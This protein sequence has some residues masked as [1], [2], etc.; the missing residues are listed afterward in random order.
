MLQSKPSAARADAFQTAVDVYEAYFKYILNVP[1]KVCDDDLWHKIKESP[2]LRTMPAF[3]DED[4]MTVMD[5]VL[6][7]KMSDDY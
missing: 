5:G 1:I 3:P 6:V 7:V 4:C 2:E